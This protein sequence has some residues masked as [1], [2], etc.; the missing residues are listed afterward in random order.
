MPL[1]PPSY[2]RMANAISWVAG[3]VEDADRGLDLQRLAGK[4]LAPAA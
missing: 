2:Y 1:G 3:Q 4:Y